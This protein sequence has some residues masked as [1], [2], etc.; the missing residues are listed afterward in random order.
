VGAGV[1]ERIGHPFSV[2]RECTLVGVLLDDREEI[3]QQPPLDLGQLGARNR[4]GGRTLDPVNRRAGGWDDRQRTGRRAVTRRGSPRTVA[5]RGRAGGGRLRFSRVQ[6]LGRGFALL[7]RNRR[8]SS[9]R[10]V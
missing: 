4:L 2:H 5:G 1:D 6:P 7:W 3:T 10:W 9:Y 8:P